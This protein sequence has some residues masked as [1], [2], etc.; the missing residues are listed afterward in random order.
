[1]AEL[2]ALIFDVDGTLADT[3]RDGH[4]VAFN[5]AFADAGLDWDWNPKLYGQL[6]AVSGGKERVR[7]YLESFNTAFRQP[8]DLDGF[9]ADL[10]RIKTG[11]YLDLLK[12]GRI[13]LRTGVERLLREARDRA[14]ALAVATTTTPANVEY[15]IE[16]TLGEKALDYFSVIAAGDM[17]PEKKPA[18]D[19]YEYALRELG[20][21]A[22]QCL[23]I[24]DSDN[25]ILSSH[26]AGIRT[27][28]TIN[29][30]TRAQDFTG[31][32][33]VLDHLGDPGRPFTVLAGQAPP[34]KRMVDVELVSS[35]LA[36]D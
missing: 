21:P 25:G 1:M 28:V 34:G 5:R 16:S 11:Y 32:A 12:A 30:Y 22:G 19:V 6:L 15:L 17:V 31:A 23:A 35:L 24:E 29:D 9:I 13:P 2:K 36:T 3:E 18:P 4:R 10:H 14:L 8:G 27:L 33:L 20:L 26:G 7:Y